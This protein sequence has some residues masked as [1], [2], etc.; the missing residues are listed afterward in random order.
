MSAA[1]R[2]KGEDRA[3]AKLSIR[4]KQMLRLEHFGSVN[5]SY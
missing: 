3:T 1:R 5:A 2:A 4:C